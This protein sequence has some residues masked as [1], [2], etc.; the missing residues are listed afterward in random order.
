LWAAIGLACLALSSCK[1]SLPEQVQST[2][3]PSVNPPPAVRATTQPAPEAAPTQASQ[4]APPAPG[5]PAKAMLPADRKDL[6]GLMGIPH[7][8]LALDIDPSLRSFEGRARID[9]TN[10]ETV[11]LDKVYLRLLPNG[12]KSYGDGSLTASEVRVNGQAAES[13][14]S[15]QDSV[16]EVDL[17][18]SLSPGQ[19]AQIEL[20]F[21]G[22]VPLDFGSGPAGYGIYNFDREQVFLSLSGWFPILAVYDEQ[23]WNLDPVSEIGDSVYSDTALYTVQVCAPTGLVLA[24]TGSRTGEQAA[25]DKTCSQFESGPVRDFYLAAS[26][27]FQVESQQVDGTQVN[28]YSLPGHEKPAQLALVV[29]RD[30]LHTYNQKFGRYPFAELDLVET[31]IRNAL[32]VEY[33]GV[34]LVAS[35]LY[36]EPQAPEFS[37]TIAHEVAHQWWYS[38]VGNDVFDDPWLDEGLA[39]YTSS[40][41]FE[42][43]RSPDFVR[44]LVGY[45]Q[46][47]YERLKTEGTDDQITESLGYFETLGDP[48]V[49]ANVVYTKAALFFHALRQEIGDE[50]FF[51]AL[52]N[53]YQAEKY[54]IAV[55]E[56]LLKAFEEAAGRPL[57]AFYKEWLYTPEK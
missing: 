47:L 25:G 39:T 11:P 23:G 6:T 45:W 16:L 30:A 34:F 7:Y 31:P 4:E 40:L 32:G 9:Y 53:Y 50:A 20:A 29:A 5:D 15:M 21:A 55:P 49:Y 44:N 38:L 36:D 3:T 2:N 46:K 52:Q 26:P 8:N 57:D 33:P 28:S 35:S 42:F 12:Q 18:A 1:P 37:I 13:R 17:P 43:G 19:A 14:L 54:G 22:Q 56:D 48:G 10:Q 51:E 24:T 27:N 41:Y